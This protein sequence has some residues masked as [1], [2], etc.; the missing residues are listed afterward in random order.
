VQQAVVTVGVADHPAR[1]RS[2]VFQHHAHAD[3]ACAKCHTTAVTL[4][5]DSAVTGC[6]ACH[7][8][9]HA[10]ARN[11][12]ACHTAGGFDPAKSHAPPVEAHTG[13]DAC[14]KTA[15]V[16]RLVPDR[17]LCLTCH[18]AQRDHY[19]NR[20]C[21]VCHFQTTPDGYREHLRKAGA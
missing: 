12:A 3:I 14:H 15:T 10:P 16:A 19:A 8:Q 13:C 17:G 5:P 1:P 4:H 21:T 2:V 6:T 18:A 20:E 11:C 7:E 9:H